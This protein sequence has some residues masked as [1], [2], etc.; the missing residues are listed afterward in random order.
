M[1]HLHASVTSD[2][3]DRLTVAQS[4]QVSRTIALLQLVKHL[5]EDTH[6]HT[7]AMQDQV[8]VNQFNLSGPSANSRSTAVRN[9][10]SIVE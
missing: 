9:I 1:V 4:H 8:V 7:Q 10:Y 5:G 2:E 3:I 6:P